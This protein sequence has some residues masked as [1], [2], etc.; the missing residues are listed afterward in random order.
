MEASLW[1]K[2][3]LIHCL[4]MFSRVVY[5][6]LGMSYWQLA[7]E[8]PNA[9]VDVEYA[10]KLQLPV[11]ICAVTLVVIGVLLDILI[12]RK[13]KFARLLIYYELLS[14][15]LQSLVPLDLGDFESMTLLMVLTN[16]FIWVGCYPR[17]NIFACIATLLFVEFVTFPMMYQQEWNLINITRKLL[18]TFFLTI[19][20]VC[21]GMLVVYII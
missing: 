16:T 12:W 6:I 17:A 9:K 19:I 13:R 21:V 11:T 4:C 20:L 3:W 2:S 15:S 1:T 7:Y 8:K 5:P 10:K 14:I 18:N